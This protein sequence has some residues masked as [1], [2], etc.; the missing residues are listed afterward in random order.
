MRHALVIDATLIAA[1]FA[2]AVDGARQSRAERAARAGHGAIVAG[3]PRPSLA[4]RAAIVALPLAAGVVLERRV[5]RWPAYPMLEAAGL[6]L[7]GAGLVLHHRA[8]QTLGPQWE[9]TVT[10]RVGHDLVTRGPY[11]VVRH[12]LYAAVLLAAAGTLLAHPSLAIACAAVGLATGTGL[13]IRA[14]ETAL[15]RVLGER[16]TRYATCVPA[17]IPR[18]SRAKRE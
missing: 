15:H 10:V 6:A 2:L 8:R 1:W 12:P 16:W 18:L 11:A 14:E 3:R 13:K 9:P 17:L 4:L 7:V 5:G